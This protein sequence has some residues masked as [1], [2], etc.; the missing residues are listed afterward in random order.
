L[1]YQKGS[2]VTEVLAWWKGL[3]KELE[4]DIE[5]LDERKRT[6]N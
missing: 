4:L 3:A 5:T 2:N 1:V 6:T